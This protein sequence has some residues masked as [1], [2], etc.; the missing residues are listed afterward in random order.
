MGMEYSKPSSGG[1]S[2]A[3]VNP[4]VGDAIVPTQEECLYAWRDR[5]MG[6][7]LFMKV[8]PMHALKATADGVLETV[9]HGQ[10][11]T[12]N[13]YQAGDYILL[14]TEGE[15]YTLGAAQF[16]ARYDVAAPGDASNAALRT[17]GFHIYRPTGAVW[18]EQLDEVAVQT[19]FPAGK[20]IAPWGSEMIFLAGDW[21]ATPSPA[22]SEVYR[23]E[24]AAFSNTYRPA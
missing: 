22:A 4:V 7:Q 3:H 19:A 23:I 8:T 6:G 11:E 2:V 17:E 16:G 21:L 13:H 20:F 15:R 12:T 14:G 10:V 18:A 5:L 9:L 1:Q 24:A